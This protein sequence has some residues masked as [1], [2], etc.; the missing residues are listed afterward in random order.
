MKQAIVIYT[1][2]NAP[3][4]LENCLN[5]IKGFFKYPI[6]I[7]YNDNWEI[8]CIKWMY[9]NTDYDEFFLMQD[10]VEIKDLSLFD[11]LFIE[12]LEHSVMIAAKA[13]S[14]LVKYR[15]KTLDKIQIPIAH[16]KREAVDY[17]WDF[18]NFDYFSMDD[19][20]TPFL[21]PNLGSQ[22]I[23]E[24]KFGKLRQKLENKYLIKYKGIWNPEMIEQQ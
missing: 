4:A 18:W 23:F 21:L 8:G 15:R 13:D 16:N 1:H 10:T 14:Y 3:G 20:I 6:I 7:L 12:W 2:H 24:E 19:N 22:D 11:K 5:S 17:E 9:E